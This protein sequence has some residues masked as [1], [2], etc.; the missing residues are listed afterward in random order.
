MPLQEL[1]P[2]F[3]LANACEGAA[4]LVKMANSYGEGI[5][6]I[7]VIRAFGDTENALQHEPHLFLI[8]ITIAGNRL[9]YFFRGIFCDSQSSLYGCSNSY[10]LGP[11]QFKHTLYVL[12]KKGGFNSKTRRL[13]LLNEFL[14]PAMNQL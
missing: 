11:A 13:V 12:A 8:S 3:C 9:F 5:C 2:A 1:L 14:Y 4:F 7:K 10:S 6:S